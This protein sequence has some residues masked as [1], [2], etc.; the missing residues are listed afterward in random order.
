MKQFVFIFFTFYALT[1]PQMTWE[2]TFYL[3]MTMQE[4][5]IIKE[6]TTPMATIEVFL[7]PVVGGTENKD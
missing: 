1:P 4:L 2:N 5:R 6:A 3:Q 7:I